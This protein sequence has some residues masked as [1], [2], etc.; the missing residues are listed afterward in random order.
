MYCVYTGKKQNLHG[1]CNILSFGK[2]EANL[3]FLMKLDHFVPFGRPPPGIVI[4]QV[5][6]KCVVS[7]I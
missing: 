2:C 5:M 6:I 1:I 3:H 4:T 7:N